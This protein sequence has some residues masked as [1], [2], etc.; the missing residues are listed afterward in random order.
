MYRLTYH[1]GTEEKTYEFEKGEVTIGRSP[2]CSIS[3]RDFGI[4]RTHAKVVVQDGSCKIVDMKSKNGTQVNGVPVVEAPLK[5]GDRVLLGK[6]EL[7]FAKALEGKV[8]LDDEKPVEEAGTIMRSV[9]DIS[10]LLELEAAKQKKGDAKPADAEVKQIEKANRILKVLTKV[11]ETLIASRPM[12]EVLHQVMEIVF[13]HIPADRGFL[14]LRGADG[15]LEPHVIKHRKSEDDSEGK[16]TI[17][18][19]IAKKVI[20]DRVAILTSDAQVDSRF[21][22]GDS[23]RIQGIRSAMCA[24]MWNQD[25]VIGIIFVDSL[26]LTNNFGEDDLDLLAA[27]ANYAAV[28][29][30]HTRLN[31]KIAAEEKKRDRLGRFLSPQVASRILAASD[32]QDDS[33]GVPELREVTVLFSDICGFTSMSEKM[34]PAAVS[35]LLSDYLSRMT[36]AVFKQEG[37]LDKYIGDA[38]MAVFGAPIDMPDHAERAIRAA[39]EMRERLD[40]FNE[41]R[42]EGPK[43]KMRIGINTGKAVAGEI[44]SINKKEYT[45]LGDTVNT[46]SR[47]ESSVAKPE[48]I[49]IGENTYAQVKDLFDVRSLGK[50]TLKG[51]EKTVQAYEVLGEAAGS[52]RATTAPATQPEL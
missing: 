49:V 29:V 42:T 40:E 48:M 50:A 44:G 25:R 22:A 26:M 41:E 12:E 46:A 36:D 17:S 9:G 24:P 45:V 19:T 20:A 35:L 11:A 30:E 23:I 13:D 15:E 2:D 10:K 43:L 3:L 27:L 6:F 31:E 18:R 7:T 47:L 5:E 38:I 4:S 21:N 28:A 8:V 16:I 34:S 37:T 52:V 14:M 32:S 33:L 51:K 1:D 39:I